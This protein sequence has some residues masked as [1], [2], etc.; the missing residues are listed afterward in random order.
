MTLTRLILAW[1]PVA[2][3]F[4]LTSLAMPLVVASLAG[5]AGQPPA[6]VA[7]PLLPLRWRVVEAALLTLFASLWFDSLG[8]GAWWLLFLL[9]GALATIPM[10]LRSSPERPP[11]RALVVGAC[12]DLARYVVAGAILAWRLG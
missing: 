2:V 1:F 5:P 11:R 8:S 10:W 6:V 4:V 9:V 3:W 12:A 7:I